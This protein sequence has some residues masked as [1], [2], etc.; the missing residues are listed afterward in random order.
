MVFIPNLPSYLKVVHWSQEYNEWTNHTGR[1]ADSDVVLA[2]INSD[3]FIAE[4]IYNFILGSAGRL[5]K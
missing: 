3:W 5:A 2:L 4:K 1:Q